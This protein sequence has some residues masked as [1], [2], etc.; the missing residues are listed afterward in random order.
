MAF[1]SR[2]LIGLVGDDMQ[3]IRATFI[4]VASFSQ[5]SS[6][7]FLC[8]L[9]CLL[10]LIIIAVPMLLLVRFSLR[11][12]PSC[13]G[14]HPLRASDGD[15]PGFDCSSSNNNSSSS[16]IMNCLCLYCDSRDVQAAGLAPVLIGEWGDISII[17]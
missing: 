9:L 4:R 17:C 15:S 7:M 11:V 1:N 12:G 2:T 8:L 10:P 16:S 5:S 6:F 13:S 3:A 14:T